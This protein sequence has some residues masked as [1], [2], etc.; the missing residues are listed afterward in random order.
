MPRTKREKEVSLT[1]VKKKTKEAKSGMINEVK[2]C[3][4]SYENLYVFSVDNMRSDLFLEVRQHFKANSRFFF[5]KNNVMAVAL[6]RTKEAE[7]QKN[8]HKMANSLKGQRGLMFTNV[9]DEKVIKYFEEFRHK[10]FARGGQ[11]ATETIEL[12]EGPLPQFSFSM[13]PQLRK[14]GLPTKL[15]KGQIELYKD[16][17]V[18]SEN[19]TLNAEQAKIL[20]ILGIKMSEFRF[21]LHKRW[22][23]ST[24]KI[25]EIEE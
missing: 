6:G 3:A 10:D 15:E 2:H 18:C 16:F 17:H 4:E 21:V 14:L 19:E 5:G 25:L 1:K 8:L 23:R 7:C 11:V 9:P 20:K 22:Q 24:G 12:S 13:E